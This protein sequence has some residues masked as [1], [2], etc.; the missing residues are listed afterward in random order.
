MVPSG[1]ALPRID[2]QRLFGLTHVVPR[3]LRLW[4]FG[5][6][7]G[8]IA[9]FVLTPALYLLAVQLSGAVGFRTA[10]LCLL[11]LT[12]TSPF[13]MEVAVGVGRAPAL[14]HSSDL[15]DQLDDDRPALEQAKEYLLGEL[16]LGP[17]PV[18]PAPGGS[19]RDLVAHGRAGEEAARRRGA[20]DLDVEFAARFGTLGVVPRTPGAGAGRVS[21][22]CQ[23]CSKSFR[24][25]GKWQRLCWP[26]WRALKARAERPRTVASPVDA[27]LLRLAILLCHPDRHP[28]ERRIFVTASRP[29]WPRR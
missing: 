8:R 12:L 23:W 19:A 29:L 18:R 15:V 24:A 4:L 1:S 13:V 7:F 26:C 28:P 3:R 25:D 10:P 11:A 6:T 9:F 16:A 21:R 5:C 22:T 27:Q 20:T 14:A 17:V 2:S